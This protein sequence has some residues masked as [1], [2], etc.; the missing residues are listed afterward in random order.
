MWQCFDNYVT[1]RRL[2]DITQTGAYVT[3][4]VSSRIPLATYCLQESLRSYLSQFGCRV[5]ARPSC[6]IIRSGFRTGFRSFRSRPLLINV[7][8]ITVAN[9]RGMHTLTVTKVFGRFV[10][11]LFFCAVGSAILAVLTDRR[12]PATRCARRVSVRSLYA[13]RTCHNSAWR[14]TQRPF[15]W[16]ETISHL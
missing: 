11:A 8:L 6:P 9:P 15:L 2:I 14:S 1:S 13:L 16:S 7:Y 3:I 4:R 10:A 5:F 12:V